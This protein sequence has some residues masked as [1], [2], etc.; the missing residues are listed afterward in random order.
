MFQAVHNAICFIEP[1]LDDIEVLRVASVEPPKDGVG[2][3]V[4]QLHQPRRSGIHEH[5]RVHQ[6]PH[7]TPLSSDSS[8]IPAQ[9]L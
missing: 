3:M 8:K 9:T 5:G 7:L 2:D 1:G 6:V 4:G